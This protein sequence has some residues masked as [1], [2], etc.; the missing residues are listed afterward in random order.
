MQLKLIIYRSLAA[1]FVIA[2]LTFLLPIGFIFT[3]LPIAAILFVAIVVPSVI[4]AIVLPRFRSRVSKIVLT[5]LVSIMASMSIVTVG[6]LLWQIS[7]AGLNRTNVS[8]YLESGPVYGVVFAPVWVTTLLLIC[9]PLLRD[10]TSLESIQGFEVL[11][12]QSPFPEK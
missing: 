11:D 12:K 6:G 2:A 4:L 5:V 3:P 9:R 7:S 8:G 1:F 10:D